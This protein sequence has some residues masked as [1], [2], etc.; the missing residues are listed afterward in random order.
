MTQS[1]LPDY[2]LT[3]DE[4]PLVPSLVLPET[5]RQELKADIKAQLKA[6]D[7]VLVADLE[8]GMFA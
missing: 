4:V 6:L 3:S 1:S 5:R 8:G 2:T 7:A